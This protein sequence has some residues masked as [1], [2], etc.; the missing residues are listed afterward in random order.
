MSLLPVQLWQLLNINLHPCQ[1]NR[2][3]CFQGY[4]LHKEAVNFP[5]AAL[6]P[7]FSLHT[8]ILQCNVCG[9]PMEDLLDS[10]FLHRGQVNCE[11]CYAKAFDWWPRIYLSDHLCNPPPIT[12][13]PPPTVSTG[14]LDIFS[15][16]VCV[17]C[18]LFWW[19][20]LCVPHTVKDNICMATKKG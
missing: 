20:K 19:W 1:F 16:L 13:R 6:K 8:S 18:F 14:E 3:L 9:K 11:S 10:M 15:C 7:H 17:F 5:I 2:I 4:W 12:P